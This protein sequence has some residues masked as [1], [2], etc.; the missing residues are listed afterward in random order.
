MEFGEVPKCLWLAG[1]V[2]PQSYLTAIRQTKA[3]RESLELDRLT[4]QTDVTKRWAEEVTES[5][6]DGAH[7]TGMYITGAT[8]DVASGSVEKSKPRQMQTLM[9]V[10]NVRSVLLEKLDMKGVFA[11]PVYKTQMRGPTYVFSAQLKTKAPSAR[12]VMAGCC[13][14]FDYE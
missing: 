10:I 13:C 7:I 12:W 9:P 5:S 1:L 4:I 14:V 6:R 8:F 2:N 3:Q 11:C